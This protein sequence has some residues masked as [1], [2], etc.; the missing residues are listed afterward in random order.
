MKPETLS[1]QPVD[2]D[3]CEIRALLMRLGI[4]MN[5]KGFNLCT[6][7]V[8]LVTQEPD[9][10]LFVSK[11]LYPDVAK[12]FDTTWRDVERNIRTAAKIAW[13]CNPDLVRELAG[14]QLPGKPKASQFISMIA[15]RF[16]NVPLIP[17]DSGT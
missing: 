11:W 8:H 12:R 9:R 17:R 15:F 3:T 14:Y 13:E 1:L 7:T 10:M 6:Y 4:A 2:V 16:L 5:Y